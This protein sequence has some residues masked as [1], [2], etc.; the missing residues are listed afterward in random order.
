MAST[1][2]MAQVGRFFLRT[3]LL[4]ALLSAVVVFGGGIFVFASSNNGDGGGRGEIFLEP[5]GS[6]GRDPFLDALRSP[7]PTVVLARDL[8]P[9]DRQQGT[10]SMSGGTVGLYGGTLDDSLCDREQMISFLGANSGQGR[11][12]AS[13]QGITFEQIP[14]YIRGLTPMQLRI[15][16]RVTNHGY[17]DG[18][19][20]ALQS[21]L[22]AGTAV[23]VDQYGVPRAR[24]A[25]GN[26]LL[27]P[28]PVEDARFVGDP[29]KD[30]DSDGLVRV[31][32]A[33]ESVRV[34]VLHN[35]AT[36]GLFDRPVGTDGSEDKARSGPAP[37]PT[38]TSS[39]S[40]KPLVTVTPS[41]TTTSTST[42]GPTTTSTQGAAAT[43]TTTA[44]PTT[45]APD[46]TPAPVTTAAP[47]ATTAAPTTSSSTTAPVTTSS[48][49]TTT[50]T[51]TTSPPRTVTVPSFSLRSLDEAEK[52]AGGTGL[53]LEPNP[54][55]N[56][57]MRCG[58]TG[59][60]TTQN[61]LAGAVV[62]L[63]SAVTVTYPVGPA[64]PSRTA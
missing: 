48:T 64:C 55:L 1:R 59:L 29:W 26:P 58:T 37:K 11:A 50:T 17:R 5:A 19:A 56:A 44:P 3:P 49:T 14:S 63:N 18:D 61:P 47:T 45:A 39:T 51:T 41:S 22:Q 12:W 28:E 40:S 46:T 21:V 36:G 4:T 16:T 33:T 32:P 31:T 27:A 57:N 43:T 30:F 53:K 60:I 2:G 6:L 8:L 35:A 13:V 24:C 54:T 34:F 23:L 9:E 42:T 10:A 38:T 62:P 7:V 20:L 25:C 52:L 15:D